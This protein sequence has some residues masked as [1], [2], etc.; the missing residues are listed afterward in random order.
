MERQGQRGEKGLLAEV[1]EVV[2]DQA[3]DVA[4]SAPGHHPSRN[5][6]ELL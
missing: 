3:K 2:V 6:R 5:G 1:V 4:E